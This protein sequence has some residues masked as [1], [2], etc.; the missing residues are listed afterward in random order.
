MSEQTIRNLAEAVP[1]R[2]AAPAKNRRADRRRPPRGNIKVTCIKGSLGLGKNIGVSVVDISEAG[3]RVVLQAPLQ[4]GQDMEVSL[5]APG[6]GQTCKA[7]AKVVWCKQLEDGTYWVGAQFHR[8]LRY[9]ELW[10]Y[11]PGA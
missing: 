6:V 4:K 8:R 10:N 1:D 11:V 2:P 5:L 3:I 7:L 9:R